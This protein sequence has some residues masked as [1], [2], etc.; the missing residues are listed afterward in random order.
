MTNVI[1]IVNLKKTYSSSHGMH[2]ALKDVSL[3][4][5]EGCIYGI[6]GLSGAG[7]STLV[8]CINGI[9][10][11][12]GGSV[13]VLGQ[14]VG[15]L[16][17]NG[18]KSL[19]RNIG[20][21]FQQFNLM[22]SRTVIQNVLL[23]LRGTSVPRGERKVK[24]ERLLELVGL[25]RYAD[26]Y[27]SQLS[28]GQQQRVA[29]ARALANDPQILLCDEATSALDPDTTKTILDLLVKL[30]REYGL[31]V[32]VVTHQMDVV[33]TICTDVSVIDQG[34]I[35]E[36]GSVYKI[37]ADP[38]ASLAKRF[39]ESSTGLNRILSLIDSGSSAIGLDEGERLIHM[40]YVDKKVSEALVSEI[41]K[42]FGL[43]V[44]IVYGSLEIIENYPLGGIIA[45]FVGSGHG[46]EESIDWL[47]SKGIKVD[48]LTPRFG[49]KAEA[50]AK[51][52]KGDD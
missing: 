32:I 37:F 38:E 49:S 11:K 47:R 12:T 6:I 16:G 19:R 46:V 36:Q 14:E 35:V 20:M 45:K 27:P 3:T 10:S 5:P 4:V 18:L 17:A 34:R 15:D 44:N 2:S 39:V 33:K 25:E 28:G 24:A 51:K 8:R 29:I 31:T 23:P 22:P 48:D 52:E 21:V 42:R 50:D 43:T 13:K 9:E 40:Q 30:N 41:T 26:A 7:K 1:E